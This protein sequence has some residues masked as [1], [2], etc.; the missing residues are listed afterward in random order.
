MKRTIIV[1]AI[2]LTSGIAALA[3]SITKTEDVKI[4]QVKADRNALLKNN[5]FGKFR[6]DIAS[7]D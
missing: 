1:L 6:S 3:L 4:A 5:E 7:A 2:I